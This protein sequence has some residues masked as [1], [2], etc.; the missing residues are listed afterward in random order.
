MKS[1]RW[2]QIAVSLCVGLATA[3]SA[4]SWPGSKSAFHDFDRYDFEIDG[5]ASIVVAPKEV[6]NGRPW[7]WR[8]RFFGHEPQTDLALLEQGFHLVYADVAGLY[9]SPKAVARWDRVYD[10]FVSERRFDPKVVLEGMSRGG[11]IIM[12]W[13]IAHPDRVHAI[14]GDAPVLDFKS[15]P[16]INEAILTAYDLSEKEAKGYK[17]NPVDA[18]GSLAKAKVPVLFVVGDIDEVVPVAENAAIF[19]ERYRE[20]GGPIRVIHKPD[21][22]HHPHSL[23]DPAPIVDFIMDA[24]QRPIP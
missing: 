14:Y 17:G 23:K 21:V 13:A 16:G 2:L 11:L 18:L 10:H 12:N 1:L 22:G 3:A 4:E 8:A 5:I 24:I 7:I 9:G 19:E 15:W 6:A 20:L